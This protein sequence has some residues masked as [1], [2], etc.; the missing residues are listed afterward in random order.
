MVKYIMK[1]K[2]SPVSL[3]FNIVVIGVCIGLVLY[4]IFSKNG[5]RDLISGDGNYA[6]GWLAAALLCH[7]GKVLIDC[8]ITWQ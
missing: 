6:W 8:T 4:F 1:K 7:I 2:K 3:I 5:L